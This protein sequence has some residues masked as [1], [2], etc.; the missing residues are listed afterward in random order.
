MQKQT[1]ILVTASTSISFLMDLIIYS[2]AQS[3]GKGFKL[4]IP[5]TKDMVGILVVGVL[6]GVAIDF[7]LN[8]LKRSIST[9]SENA[10]ADLVDAE[11]EKIRKGEI[12]D[13][14]PVEIIYLPKK[15]AV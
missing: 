13:K 6:M 12:K 11:V 10:L 4:H 7:T 2:S 1:V 14:L 9:D 5:P 8:K 15:N 3:Q